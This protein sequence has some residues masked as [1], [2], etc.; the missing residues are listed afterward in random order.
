M[1]CKILITSR[2]VKYY[3]NFLRVGIMTSL[4]KRNLFIERTRSEYKCPLHN[5][6]TLKKGVFLFFSKIP[7]FFLILDQL[8]HVV[9]LKFLQL[10][11]NQIQEEITID[12]N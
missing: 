3:E 6:L 7:S 4:L 1:T 12:K 9:F 8:S 11:G 10:A 5:L 2:F